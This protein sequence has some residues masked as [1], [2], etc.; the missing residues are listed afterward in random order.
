MYRVKLINEENFVS[1]S[2]PSDVEKHK[3]LISYI[4]PTFKKLFSTL[5]PWCQIQ[6]FSFYR[7]FDHSNITRAC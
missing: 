2:S 7:L 3:A 4:E 1:N 5:L 6:S